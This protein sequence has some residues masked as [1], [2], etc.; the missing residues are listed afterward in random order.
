LAV[1][2]KIESSSGFFQQKLLSWESRMTPPRQLGLIE[3]LCGTH[4]GKIKFAKGI[5]VV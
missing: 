1:P 3:G 4:P 5:S 2:G